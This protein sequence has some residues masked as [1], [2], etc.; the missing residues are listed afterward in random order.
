LQNQSYNTTQWERQIKHLDVNHASV[1]LQHRTDS[2]T[3]H[4][5]DEPMY[6]GRP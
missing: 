5:A 1:E 2:E 6:L 4:V 3:N